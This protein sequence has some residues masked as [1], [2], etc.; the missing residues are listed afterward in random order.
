MKESEAALNTAR[1]A[2]PRDIVGEQKQGAQ[3]GGWGK[4]KFT[5][6]KWKIIQEWVHN[7]RINSVLQILNCK[8]SASPCIF[9]LMWKER[10]CTHEK[11]ILGGNVTHDN[12]FKVAGIWA[13]VFFIF[14][15][16]FRTYTT[17]KGRL[18]GKWMPKQSGEDSC[19][20]ITVSVLWNAGAA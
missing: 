16:F 2:S 14:Q 3:H 1:D 4:S 5:V 8:P 18:R 6:V 12:S 13:M 15:T 10:F 17:L 19:D 7:T 9:L 11:T 20:L